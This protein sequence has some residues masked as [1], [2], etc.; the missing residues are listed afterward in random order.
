VTPSNDHH[1]DLPLAMEASGDHNLDL[2]P[3]SYSTAMVATT[4]TTTMMTTAT[5][6]HLHGDD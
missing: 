4:T 6:D 5:M 2:P 1:L 3:A